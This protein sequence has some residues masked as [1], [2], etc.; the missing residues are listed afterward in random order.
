MEK[1]EYL[2]DSLLIL[3]Y[4]YGFQKDKWRKNNDEIYQLPNEMEKLASYRRFLV[5]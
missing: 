1:L 5:H 4:A 3:I 2:I